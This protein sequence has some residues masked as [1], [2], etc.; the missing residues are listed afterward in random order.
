MDGALRTNT[1]ETIEWLKFTLEGA[2]ERTHGCPF[3]DTTFAGC[4]ICRCF[5]AL[6]HKSPDCRTSPIPGQTYPTTVCDGYAKGGEAVQDGD[7]DRELRDLTIKV[8]RG[9]SLAQQ[10][11]TMRLGFDAA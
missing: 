1:N 9:Q 2:G 10:F 3:T 5:V 6:L 8:P 4:W 11:D 7:P